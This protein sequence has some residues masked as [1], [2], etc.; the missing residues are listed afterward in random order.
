MS[1]AAGNIQQRT[2]VGQ[3]G[4]KYTL[5]KNR[6][7]MTSADGASD[8]GDYIAAC[9]IFESITSTC[10]E[11]RFIVTDSGGL[12]SALTGSEIIRV[13]MQTTIQNRIYYFRIYQITARSKSGQD[14]DL[15]MFNAVSDEFLKNEIVNIFG[16]SDQIFAGKG[17]DPKK[18]PKGGQGGRKS[19]YSGGVDKG[20]QTAVPPETEASQVIT[21]LMKD[22]K[23]I[24]S[25]KKLF[26]EPTLNKHSFIATNWRPFD[27]IYWIS[28]RSIRITGKG[29]TLQNGF[30]FYENGLGFHFKS[31]DKMIDD[32][33]SMAISTPTNFETG[34][35]KLYE[36]IYSKK[37]VHSQIFD[38]FKIDKVIFP[39]EKSSLSG[40]RHGAWSGYSIGFDP[41]NISSSKMGLSTEMSVDAYRYNIDGLW[42]KMS[43]VGGNTNV[44]PIKKMDNDYQAMINYPKRVRYTAL[45]NQIF[46]QK[47]K[48]NPQKNY[49]QLVELQ[50][51]QWLRIE[52][53]KNIQLTIQVPGNLD[54]YSGGGIK[55]I[56]PD[57]M[58]I[59]SQRG[60]DPKYSG[61]YVI[62]A[63][64]HKISNQLMTT[65]L[66]LLKDS[67]EQGSIDPPTDSS[68]GTKDPNAGV[69]NTY[70]KKENSGG[71]K[72]P[73]RNRR[74]RI[75]GYE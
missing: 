20:N 24:G 16:H 44:N 52:T 11:A 2:Q 67:V 39:D 31:I 59:G 60:A 69:D 12:V 40:L 46:D 34:L 65:E 3:V 63:L 41:T 15:Y 49:E 1:E 42:S 6:E 51:Y 33:N 66:M 22:K 14:T 43:H 55:V 75:V 5:F 37:N 62:A 27:T 13:D 19:R 17:P 48:D 35:P 8:M 73:K 64:S 56:L 68:G 7:K 74:G 38:Q 57:H 23:Y 30:A 10:M 47:Y 32:V 26:L 45:S 9:E 18:R 70:I 54:L 58:P 28:N 71:K 61:R 50:A 4:V 29:G 21:K 36:Y 72:K 53:F 25:T